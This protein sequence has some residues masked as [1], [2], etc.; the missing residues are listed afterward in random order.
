MEQTFLALPA[1]L[2]SVSCRY[3]KDKCVERFE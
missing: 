2:T 1:V 3:A